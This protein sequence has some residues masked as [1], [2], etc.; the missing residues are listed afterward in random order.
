[1][2][3]PSWVA[4]HGMAHSFIELDKGV[5]HVIRLVS[6]LWLWFSVW[7]SLQIW[8]I[9][10][11]SSWN[12][13]KH[14]K[15]IKLRSSQME[16]THKAKHGGRGTCLPCLLWAYYSPTS[17]RF[18]QPGSP[19]NPGLLFLFFFVET[20]L[21]YMAWLIKSLAT[22]DWTQSPVPLLSLKVGS[23][24]LKG[25]PPVMGLVP[26]QPTPTL[27]YLSKVILFA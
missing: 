21:H 25:Q 14:Y 13:G 26:W 1:M 8:L 19:L 4:L 15:R 11:S 17:P 7:V 12:S 27:R 3:Y 2:T 23:L 5:V 10:L 24:W 20:S 22:G 9:C 16:E 18:Y 6:F